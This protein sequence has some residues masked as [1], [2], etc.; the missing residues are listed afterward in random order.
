MRSGGWEA[1]L[2]GSVGQWLAVAAQ[3]LRMI[4]SFAQHLGNYFP[5]TSSPKSNKWRIF[6]ILPVWHA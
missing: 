4:G 2:V 3:Q 6:S 1:D 5:N